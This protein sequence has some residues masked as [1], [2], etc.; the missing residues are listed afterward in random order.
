MQSVLQYKTLITDLFILD[1][2]ELYVSLDA[3]TRIPFLLNYGEFTHS[4]HKQLLVVLINCQVSHL[5]HLC[6]S[7]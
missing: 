1:I 2:H 3:S 4:I 7:S 5:V 6:Y